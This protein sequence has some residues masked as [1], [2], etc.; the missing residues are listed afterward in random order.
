[1]YKIVS[2]V[3]AETLSKEVNEEIDKGFFPIGGVCCDGNGSDCRTLYQA[4][5][6]K[7][8]KQ[9]DETEYQDHEFCE[10]IRCASFKNEK[11]NWFEPFL[12]DCGCHKSAKRFH[13]WLN[14]N[15]FKIVRKVKK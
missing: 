8:E 4:M 3:F 6:S 15:G 14:E 1:M 12:D 13:K 11:C 9:Q 2:D 7:Q 10:S 5:I